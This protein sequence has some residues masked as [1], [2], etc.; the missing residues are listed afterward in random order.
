M[1]PCFPS[2]RGAD[3]IQILEFFSLNYFH[4]HNGKRWENGYELLAVYQA[5]KFT[6]N[7]MAL[8]TVSSSEM[9]AQ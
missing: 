1:A 8:A 2:L 3:A 7:G 9:I 6:Q 5:D 4:L